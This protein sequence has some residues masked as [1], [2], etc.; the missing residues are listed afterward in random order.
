MARRRRGA[1]HAKWT[2]VVMRDK[3]YARKL[4]QDQ[5]DTIIEFP[6][7]VRMP[8]DDDNLVIRRVW[9]IIYDER[10]RRN[11]G[12]R[13]LRFMSRIQ[14]CRMRIRRTRVTSC[15]FVLGLVMRK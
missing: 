2:E 15:N 1:P 9:E 14:K 13:A 4:M 5:E 11:S 8:T 6:G 12:R 3:V 10:N 7:A